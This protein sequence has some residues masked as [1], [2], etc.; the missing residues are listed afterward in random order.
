[1][2]PKI[3]VKENSMTTRKEELVLYPPQEMRDDGITVEV[4]RLGSVQE[5]SPRL[6]K[7]ECVAIMNGVEVVF[8]LMHWS[9]KDVAVGNEYHFDCKQGNER[10]DRQG[11]FT[12]EFFPDQISKV[13]LISGDN[14]P[15]N[16]S[17]QPAPVAAKTTTV[18]ASSAEAKPD[19]MRV[20]AETNVSF[21]AA[22]ERATQRWIKVAD[23]FA[24]GVLKSDNILEDL[25]LL[26]THWVDMY[27]AQSDALIE[28]F[29]KSKEKGSDDET[30]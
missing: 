15:D 2:T 28:T 13:A 12:G 22:H 11:N 4:T 5:I 10:K 16:L 20:F 17:Q 7:K 8:D 18:S 3:L 6:S 9:F 21:R 25:N 23:L 27:I 14:V 30:A 1:M 29:T 19:I 26:Y 24:Q